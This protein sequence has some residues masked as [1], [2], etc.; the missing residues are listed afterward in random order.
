[1]T[2]A[3]WLI[4]HEMTREGFAREH[5]LGLSTVRRMSKGKRVSG[6]VALKVSRATGGAVTVEELLSGAPGR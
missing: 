6:V 5:D 3:E 4:I 1:M 2:F